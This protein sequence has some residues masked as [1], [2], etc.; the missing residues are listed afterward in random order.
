MQTQFSRASRRLTL[1]LMI[2]SACNAADNPLVVARAKPKDARPARM[3][4]HMQALN[5]DAVDKWQSAIDKVSPE[6]VARANVG[7]F[8]TDFNRLYTQDRFLDKE[9]SKL[10][11]RM[12]LVPKTEIGK[13]ES[14]LTKAIGSTLIPPLPNSTAALIVIIQQDPL[15]ETG[16]FDASKGLP[17]VQRI[18]TIPHSAVG[19]VS[20][21]ANQNSALEDTDSAL[22]IASYDP[23][24][25]NNVFQPTVWTSL[26]NSTPTPSPTKKR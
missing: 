7:I 16:Q 18:R 12:S 13:W 19:V 24:F 14:A 21:A 26:V 9:S 10:V 25:S 22:S 11:G 15:F 17:L 1:L 5:K 8:L 3:V 2:A 4:R 6:P 23:L 20:K